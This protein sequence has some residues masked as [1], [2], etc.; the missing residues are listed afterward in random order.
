MA[1]EVEADPAASIAMTRVTLE[2]FVPLGAMA[3]YGL[4]G[5]CF[6]PTGDKVLRIEVPYSNEAGGSWPDSLAE[7]VDDVRLGLPSEFAKVVLDAAADSAS[8]RFPPGSLR[9]VEA[10]HGMVGSSP[11]FFRRVI[12]CV[13]ELMHERHLEDSDM[14]ALLRA[15]L[16]G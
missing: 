12:I 10:A 9:I 6:E 14:A 7:G 4:L 5:V 3:Q 11:N 15:G 16:T 13:L 8:R 2:A 1:R